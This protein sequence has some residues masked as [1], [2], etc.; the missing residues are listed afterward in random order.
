M[1][2][3]VMTACMDGINAIIFSMSKRTA[4]STLAADQTTQPADIPK[5]RAYGTTLHEPDLPAAVETTEFA[6]FAANASMDTMNVRTDVMILHA[7]VAP[8]RADVTFARADNS[9]T[10]A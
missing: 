3:D 8:I 6:A 9:G 5:Q 7:D 2:A 1:H 10:V 4:E